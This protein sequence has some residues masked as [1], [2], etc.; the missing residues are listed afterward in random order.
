MTPP[1]SGRCLCGAVTYH[2]TEPPLWQGHCHCESCRR[3][4]ASPFTSYFGVADGAWAFTG[5]PPAEYE[6]SP[7]AIRQFCPRCGTQISYRSARFPGER[8]FFA[9]T[10]DLPEAFAPTRH[11]F[12]SER[13]P[14]L[15]LS[16]GLPH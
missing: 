6:S 11:Y 15:H 10:L 5:L 7:G 14:W 12:W 2:C 1:Y 16:D 9:A 8:H 3:A 4:T 13:L